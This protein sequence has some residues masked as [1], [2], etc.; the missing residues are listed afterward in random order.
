MKL[1]HN[2]NAALAVLG[3]IVQPALAATLTEEQAAVVC[4]VQSFARQNG[5]LER[6]ENPDYEDIQLLGY[7][8]LEY[9]IDGETDWDRL[10]ADREGSY[11]DLLYAVS[12][13][14]D[15]EG[16]YSVYYNTESLNLCQEANPTSGEIIFSTIRFCE[17]SMPTT[18]V[19][20]SDIVCGN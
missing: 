8:E 1:H 12:R 20:Q 11:L 14:A 19:Q 2:V 15:E 3:L 4:L 5:F 13:E 6:L 7:D 16:W 18:P 10:L 17:I 9:V